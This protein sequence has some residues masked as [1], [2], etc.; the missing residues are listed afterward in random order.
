MGSLKPWP[1]RWPEPSFEPIEPIPEEEPTG[2]PDYDIEENP[3]EEPV[4]L[5]EDRLVPYSA[6]WEITHRCNL[7]CRHCCG[8]GNLKAYDLSTT[9]AVGIIE[10]L[11]QAGI[12]FIVFSGGEPLMRRDVFQLMK[13]CRNKGLG[14]A[15]RCNGTLITKA[16]AKHLGNLGIAV[17]GVSVDGATEE[18]HNFNRGSGM[19]R[20]TIHGI[21]QLVASGLRVTMEVVLSERNAGECLQLIRLAENLG[22][23]EVNFSALCPVGRTIETG[24][25]VLRTETWEQVTRTLYMA[26]KTSGISVSPACPLTGTCWSC[27]EPNINCSGWI[28]PC[29]LSQRRLFHVFDVSPDELHMRLKRLR[30]TTLNSCGRLQWLEHQRNAGKMVIK[31]KQKKKIIFA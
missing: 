14:V 31:A 21:N 1:T 18:T 28:T 30:P 9:E 23:A 10:R 24:R 2:D 13:H 26:S 19:F 11:H 3:S 25:R 16:A 7:R 22:V 17:V 8:Y 29:Y 12:R 6:T 27:V 5:P 4:C 20:K 15:L